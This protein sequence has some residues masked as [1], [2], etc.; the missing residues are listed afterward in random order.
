MIP[1]KNKKKIVTFLSDAQVNF[2]SSVQAK[3]KP[4]KINPKWT[5]K[6]RYNALDRHY[7]ET[8]SFLCEEM[9]RLVAKIEEKDDRI[10]ILLNRVDELNERYDSSYE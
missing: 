7:N 4:L 6:E 10:K 5:I 1:M 3:V 9:L 2:L 8:V